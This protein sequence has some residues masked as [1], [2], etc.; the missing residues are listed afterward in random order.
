M[1]NKS[2]R[3]RW[4]FQAAASEIYQQI[5]V[6]FWELSQIYGIEPPLL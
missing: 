5:Y 6:I 1:L 2:V 4:E 3:R